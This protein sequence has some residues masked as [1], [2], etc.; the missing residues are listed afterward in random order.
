LLN[1]GAVFIAI[2]HQQALGGARQGGL[3]APLGP[4]RL[5]GQLFAA[6]RPS[7]RRARRGEPP[8]RL[9]IPRQV[10]ERHDPGL[11]LG[12]RRRTVETMRHR[13]DARSRLTRQRAR[14][15]ALAGVKPVG[16]ALGF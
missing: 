7:Q 15:G 4:G 1:P 8:D 13:I 12:P 6:P 2:Q 10:A 14:A 16:A 5:D 3:V 11:Q 9:A